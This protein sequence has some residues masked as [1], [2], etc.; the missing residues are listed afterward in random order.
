[1]AD[2]AVIED[3]A[4]A[5]PNTEATAAPVEAPVSGEVAPVETKESKSF[6]QEELDKIVSKRLARERR[7]W[8]REAKPAAETPAASGEPE[9]PKLED[10]TDRAEFDKAVDEYA[11]KKAQHREAVKA[12]EKRV[13]RM[14]RERKDMMLAHADREDDAVEKYEDY[15]QVTRNP[16]LT[17]TDTM[18]DAI[19]LSEIGP[20]IAYHLGKHP[21]ESTRIAKLH[22]TAQAKEIGKL[23]AKIS[24]APP[25]KTSAAPPPIAA[26]K[27]S[28]SPATSAPSDSDSTAVW[29][30]KREAQLRAKAAA[31]TR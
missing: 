28:G 9:R 2:E 27:G 31:R 26:L 21:E 15:H 7:Q 11:D 19:V 17:V 13:A 29:L 25:P 16:K 10:Y 14:E 4:K 23:E 18:L 8:E 30:K 3:P 5:A 22:P 24:S 20:E 6:T 12:E 1:M